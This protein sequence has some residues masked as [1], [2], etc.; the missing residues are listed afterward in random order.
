MVFLHE[1][2]RPCQPELIDALLHVANHETV[3][4]A[5]CLTGMAAPDSSVP[6][7]TAS[8]AASLAL[9]KGAFENVGNDTEVLLHQVTILIFINQN[10]RKVTAVFHSRL[11]R[12]NPA[13]F[14]WG[15]IGARERAS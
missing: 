5:F 1:K 4:T 6:E 14:V 2:L 13:L 8:G 10:L 11:C 3:K 12:F 15:I 9:V 7:T